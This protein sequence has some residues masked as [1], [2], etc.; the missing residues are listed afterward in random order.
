M[1][2]VCLSSLVISL[3]VNIKFKTHL[4]LVYWFSFRTQKHARLFTGVFFTA[5]I[6]HNRTILRSHNACVMF[7]TWWAS[8]PGA[9]T[10]EQ[11]WIEK[12]Y[13]GLWEAAPALV[14]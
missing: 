13:E 11:R 6:G 3:T 12:K 9:I 1:T 7:H 2:K 10:T 8:T 14:F 5:L 4:C